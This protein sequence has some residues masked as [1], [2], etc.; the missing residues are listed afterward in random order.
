MDDSTKF[1]LMLLKA[2][3]SLKKCMYPQIRAK[4]I[5]MFV[6]LWIFILYSNTMCMGP[7]PF[8]A[9][10]HVKLHMHNNKEVEVLVYRSFTC[11]GR[12]LQRFFY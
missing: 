7:T 3:Q 9:D 6:P 5:T 10:V 2:T 12:D 4:T 11:L 1:L 8:V